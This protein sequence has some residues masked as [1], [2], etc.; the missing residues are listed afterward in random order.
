M[1][2]TYNIIAAG[3]GGQG[4][5]AMGQLMAYAG[6]LEGKS[7]S[8]L[9][10]Y[11]P[12]MRGGAANCSVVVSP[13]PVGSP[14]ISQATDI[15][16]MNDFSLRQFEDSVEPGGN[17]LIN[18]SL[19]QTEPTR[20]DINIFKLPVSDL[21]VELG[22]AKV[23]NM[24]MLGAFLEVTHMVKE[25]SVVNAFTKVY[26]D[27]KKKLLPINKEALS[28]GMEAIRTGNC[29]GGVCEILPLEKGASI[30]V[31][32]V[33]R[34]PQAHM[35]QG[36]VDTEPPKYLKDIRKYS[37]MNDEK[38]FADEISM[39]KEALAIEKGSINYYEL[40]AKQL[41]KDSL[42]K[43]FSSLAHQSKE[44]VSYLEGLQ[45]SLEEQDDR[46]LVDKIKTAF[47]GS[48]DLKLEDVNP[49]NAQLALSIISEGINIKRQT[50]KFYE[51]A[52]QKTEDKRAAGLYDELAYW[53]N[54]QLEQLSGQ[55][56]IYKQEWW[57]D[58]GYSPI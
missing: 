58:Q 40:S 1:M 18:S 30:G 38:I 13:E 10:S 20:T 44:H 43:I 6:M 19:V 7:V 11:G 22:N 45:K 8:W 14:V 46:G 28:A 24:V 50:I 54:F 2:K 31:K 41:E 9:P 56:E 26:G 35:R 17:L 25:E 15:V 53:E 48:D 51:K 49:E 12:E 5:M 27:A 47:T 23:A 33:S 34:T 39:V 55:Y 16:V 36:N 42:G 4:I 21:A 52:A 32:D 57:S 3:F 37:E 29:A